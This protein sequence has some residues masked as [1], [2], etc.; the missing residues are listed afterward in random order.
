[1]REPSPSRNHPYWCKVHKTASESVT[2]ACLRCRQPF[3]IHEEN[4]SR[5]RHREAEVL[6]C[7]KCHHAHVLIPAAMGRAMQLATWDEGAPAIQ[8]SME[9]KL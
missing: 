7:P 2:V 3:H 5:A 4:L 8:L 6:G 1:M 9:V